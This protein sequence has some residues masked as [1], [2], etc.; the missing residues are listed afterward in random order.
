MEVLKKEHS[1]GRC[2]SSNPNFLVKSCYAEW[3]NFMNLLE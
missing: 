3:E 2:C 1:T